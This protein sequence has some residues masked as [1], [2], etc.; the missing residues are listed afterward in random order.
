MSGFNILGVG[1][2]NDYQKIMDGLIAAEHGPATKR[3]TKEQTDTDAKISAYGELRNAISMFQTAVID[4]KEQK[5][6]ENYTIS[7]SNSSAFQIGL[8]SESIQPNSYNL[9]VTNV[10][11]AHQITSKSFD[12]PSSSLNSSGTLS[13]SIDDGQFNIDILSN[14]S[15][16]NIRDVINEKI[17]NKLTASIINDGV[18]SYLNISSNDAGTSNRI[19]INIQN[20]ND[21]NNTDDSGL[22]KFYF[23]H[24]NL[25]QSNMNEISTASDATIILNGITITNTRSNNFTE[26]LEGIDIKVNKTTSSVETFAIG[27]DKSSVLPLIESMVTAFNSM[28]ETTSAMSFYNTSTGEKGELFSDS[29]LRTFYNQIYGIISDKH[30]GFNDKYKYFS[31]L[32]IEVTDMGTLKLNSTKLN[33]AIDNNFKDVKEFFTD[34]DNGFAKKLNDNLDGYT[35]HDGILSLVESGLYKTLEKIQI[36]QIDLETDVQKYEEKLIQEFTRLDILVA[37][38]DLL[39]EQLDAQLQSLVDFGK[40]NN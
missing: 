28:H 40:S 2:G 35:K 4:I 9:S 26:A 14:Y 27:Y 23:D 10:G 24:S 16:N 8:D 30:F 1:S 5:N 15:L 22:S 19:T 17:N 7:Q 12:D 39:N 21:G 38:F 13:I 6:F 34:K 11:V 18:N 3:L 36:D 32:G 29:T 31:D 37:K 33:L 20:D 25:S